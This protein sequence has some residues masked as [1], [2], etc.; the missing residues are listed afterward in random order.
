MAML[1]RSS[2]ENCLITATSLTT[3]VAMFFSLLLGLAGLANAANVF[4][5][6]EITYYSPDLVETKLSLPSGQHA[7]YEP[8]AVTLMTFNESLVS[9][10]MITSTIE[11]FKD[12][13]DVYSDAFLQGLVITHVESQDIE[14]SSD[15]EELIASFG[16]GVKQF[17]IPDTNG[18]MPGPYLLHPSGKLTRV[19]RMHWDYNAV[20]AQSVTEGRDGTFLPVMAAVA[21]DVNGVLSAAVPSRLY[22]PPPSEDLPLS[23][24]RLVLKDIIDL[25]GIRSSSGSRS[26]RFLRDPAEKTAPAVQDLIDLGAVVIGKVKTS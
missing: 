5:R 15:A 12:R 9:S 2:V 17:T 7:F 20:F 16:C 13:D 10:D 22:Y 11:D 25:K 1:A 26:W 4:V 8:I 21:D 14:L 24:L 23:G 3:I 6:N 18:T 19:Y